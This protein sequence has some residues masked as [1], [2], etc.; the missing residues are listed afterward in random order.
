MIIRK[1][2][3]IQR[4]QSYVQ[5]NNCLHSLFKKINMFYPYIII[6]VLSVSNF[7]IFKN[8]VLLYL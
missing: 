6:I 2:F 5:T 3:I 8:V 1:I 4:K 7:N